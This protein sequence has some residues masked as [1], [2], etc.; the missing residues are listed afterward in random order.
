MG[1]HATVDLQALRVQV[2]QLASTV[3]QTRGGF[4]DDNHT[5]CNEVERNLVTVMQ[6]IRRLWLDTPLL[7][8][9]LVSPS[10]RTRAALIISRCFGHTTCRLR[11]KRTVR[12]MVEQ[13][14][15]WSQV[16]AL[17]RL[18]VTTRVSRRQRHSIERRSNAIREQL[19][20][21]LCSVDVA[22]DVAAE[23]EGAAALLNIPFHYQHED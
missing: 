8:L 19:L 9:T 7:A 13:T 4:F 1:R 12:N 21:T 2:E 6:E 23:C 18:F 11:L 20:D 10:Q 17:L 3:A 14:P 22:A 5:A 16:S 15:I